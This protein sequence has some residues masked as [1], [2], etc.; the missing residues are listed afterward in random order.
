MTLLLFVALLVVVS[1]CTPAAGPGG[2]APPGS[3]QARGPKTLTIAVLREP[4]TIDGFT[5]EGGSRG[6]AGEAGSLMH[7]LLT[8]TDPYEMDQPQLAVELP[9]AE[10]GTWRVNADGSME[11]TW[12]L[13][14]NARWHD[15]VPFTS[16]DVVFSLQLHKDPELAH[17]YTGQARIMQSASAP[18][19]STVVIHWSRVD[20]RALDTRVI[21]PVAR[22]L[23]E[24]IYATD[25]EMFINSPRFTG[26]FVGLGPYRLVNWERGSHMEM[27]RFDDYWQGRPPIDRV[28]LR[29]IRD[30]SALL[31]NA[32]AEAVDLVVP[33][34]IEL[35]QAAELKRRWEGTGHRVRVEPIPRI[36][37]FELQMGQ[38][39][40]RPRNGFPS[41]AV[42]HGLYHALDR[43]ALA[44]VMNLGLG[45]AADS[46]FRPDEPLRRE[47]ESAIPK[48]PY[49]R[50]RAQQLLSQAGWERG[51]DGTLVHAS[52]GERFE[53]ELWM[54]PQASEKALA[55]VADQ[56]KA[57][58]VDA[59]IYVIPPARAEDREHTAQHPGPLLT[60][61]FLDALL[62]RY[63]GRDIAS[64]ANRWSGRNRANYVSARADTLLDRLATTVDAR[65]RV[66]LLREQVQT[67]MGDVPLMPLYWE[68][69]PIL[70]LRGVRGDIHPHNSG[71]N[72]FTW[73]KE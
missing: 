16:A 11:I 5:G 58:G 1:A 51:A 69:R 13:R 7:D 35:E 52:S 30:S 22:H 49:D 45:P 27:A 26:E 40:A 54:N 39:L 9:S 66:P 57:V 41:L 60:G 50:A 43:D 24:S 63:D 14:E 59:K 46:W 65:E 37:Y 20:V 44:D 53:T 55:I 36:Q 72:V 8:V 6:G 68:P 70:A 61:S 4:A 29:F 10:K 19:A 67:I 31:A 23:L 71:W 25:K 32:L 56:W 18:D 48:Y 2:A 21:A 47:V 3:G 42:R 12:K 28:F 33:P 62:V 73:D 38:E 15:G 64:A 34:S 17:A